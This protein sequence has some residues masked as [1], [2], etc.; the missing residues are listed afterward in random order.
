[1]FS[2]CVWMFLRGV[3]FLWVRSGGSIAPLAVPQGTDVGYAGAG[4]SESC[5]ESR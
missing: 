3:F 5:M 1:M 4:G 2:L